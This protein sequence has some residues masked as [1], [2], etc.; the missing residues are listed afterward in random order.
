MTRHIFPYG[1]RFREDRQIE[2]FPAAEL[3]I[4]GRG[5]R[6]IR[7]VLHIDSGATLSVLPASDARQLGIQ[8][9]TGKKMLVKGVSGEFLTGYRHTVRVHVGD[10]KLKI[11]VV[12]VEHPQVPAILGREG[13]F[14]SFAIVFDEA[15][16]GVAFMD[17]NKERKAI[18][19]LLARAIANGDT[20]ALTAALT[21][22]T[23]Q[24]K[25]RK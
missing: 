9:S 23:V 16:R 10:E 14:T 19:T 17:G 18:D 2:L 11:P 12:F 22:G 1:I 21:S 24:V 5:S 25:R 6:G 13:V 7:V 15:R 4:E 3:L 20:Q 8:L